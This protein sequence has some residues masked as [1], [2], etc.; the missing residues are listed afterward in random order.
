MS[1]VSPYW[2][3]KIETLAKDELRKL[4]GRKLRAAV[5]RA[6]ANSAFHK[7]TFDAKN[8][9]PDKV[10]NFKDLKRLPFT[11]RADWMDCQLANPPFGDL[12]A[13]PMEFLAQKHTLSCL[14]GLPSTKNFPACPSMMQRQLFLTNKNRCGSTSAPWT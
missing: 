6:Y 13:R 7:R 3:P 2:N 11:T 10:R 1:P 5:E 14:K 9:G 12:V 8:V 4:Q